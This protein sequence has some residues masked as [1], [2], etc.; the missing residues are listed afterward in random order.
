MLLRVSPCQP[1]STRAGSGVARTDPDRPGQTPDQ[2]MRR[3]RASAGNRS[4]PGCGQGKPLRCATLPHE[5]GGS[6]PSRGIAAADSLATGFL[7]VDSPVTGFLAVDS[8][9]SRTP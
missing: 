2:E 5:D 8:L 9:W 7:A 1:V 3:N 4:G 6:F